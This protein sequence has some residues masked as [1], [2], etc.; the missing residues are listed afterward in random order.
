MELL[1]DALEKAVKAVDPSF[2][3]DILGS[4]RRGVEF[5]SD[6]DL[7]LRHESFINKD[8]DVVADKLM[9]A[10]VAE[11]EKR[12]LIDPENTLMNGGKKYAVRFGLRSRK[13]TS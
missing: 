1:R 5:S 4:Y 3:C 8:D 6:I 2:E 9:K 7:A 13:P 11:L 10:V 12:E